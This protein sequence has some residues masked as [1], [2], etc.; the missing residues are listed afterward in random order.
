MIMKMI[1][2]NNEKMIM[3]MKKWKIEIN[4]IWKIW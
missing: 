4:V 3:I 2:M 1:L